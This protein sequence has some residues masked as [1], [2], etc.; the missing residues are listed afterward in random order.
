MGRI[1]W[2]A[3]R[4]NHAAGNCAAAGL[5]HMW[6]LF[7]GGGDDARLK[8][9]EARAKLLEHKI[10]STWQRVGA[11]DG[12]LKSVEHDVSAVG[13]RFAADATRLKTLEAA[14]AALQSTIEKMQA[15]KEVESILHSRSPAPPPQP[16]PP[17]P[18]PLLRP[19]E[20]VLISPKK[21]EETLQRGTW[22]EAFN[23]TFLPSSVTEHAAKLVKQF[24]ASPPLEDLYQFGVFTGGSLRTM[25]RDW[26]IHKLPVRRVWAFD[27]F[28]GLQRGTTDEHS[29]WTAG[30]YSAADQLQASTF[31]EVK[32]KILD[33]VVSDNT[34]A[35]E[36]GGRIDEVTATA[37]ASRI[38]FIRGY[39]NESLTPTLAGA[40]GMR[41]AAYVDIDVDQYF[42][43]A[44]A[45]EWLFAHKLVRNGTLIGYDDWAATS[46]QW[47]S[48]ESRAHKEVAMR[49]GV[50][51]ELVYTRCGSAHGAAQLNAPCRKIPLDRCA[52]KY[53]PAE[54]KFNTIFRVRQVRGLGS[55]E[56]TLC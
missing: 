1:L 45:L 40:H 44:Q 11:S 25:R 54:P 35:K 32:T 9:I 13:P 49:Y 50:D 51:F 46:P 5:S 41:P 12:R 27:S 21:E 19:T 55:S 26:T 48:G 24:G 34:P 4:K 18:P 42:A 6:S 36:G 29:T 31:S 8:A 52:K 22:R 23:R 37:F 30:A 28:V 16:L 10:S 15:A 2:R 43:A 39:Y 7:S 56:W 3:L 17:S 53:A 33:H 14:V 38:R 47:E 20:G